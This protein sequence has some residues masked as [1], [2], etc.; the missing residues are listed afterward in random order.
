MDFWSIFDPNLAPTWPPKSTKIHEKSM[1]RY[2]PKIT[3]FFDRF[4]VP[5]STPRTFKIIVFPIEKQGFFLNIAF[6]SWDRFLMRFWCQLG[7]ILP[8]QIHQNPSKIRPQEPSKFW[9]I[10]ASIFSRFWLRFGDQVGAMLATFFEPRR[11]KTPQGRPQDAPRRTQD[12][13][14]HPKTPQDPP[15]TPPRRP[16]PSPDDDVGRILG[17]FSKILGRFLEDFWEKNPV[18]HASVGDS[19]SLILFVLA[20]WRVRSFAAL[21][22]YIYIYV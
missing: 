10:F 1:P 11:P 12:T 15:K 21:L 2:L 8:S 5:T 19:T 20:R 22:D 18:Q 4:L 14:R 16:K 17:T 7:S 6:R 3:S 9:S 13:Q